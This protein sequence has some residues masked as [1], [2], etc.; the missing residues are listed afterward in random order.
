MKSGKS[1]ISGKYV[2]HHGLAL[3]VMKDSDTYKSFCD[4]IL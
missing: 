4:E 1:E 3:F 2:V